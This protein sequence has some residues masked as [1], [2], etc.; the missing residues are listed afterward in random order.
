M[1]WNISLNVVEFYLKFLNCNL[2]VAI[3]RVIMLSAFLPPAVPS[4]AQPYLKAKGSTWIQL[5]WVPLVCDG[6]YD[7]NSYD[8]GYKPS[9]Y[10]YYTTA[11]RTSN[12]NITIENLAA[13][14]NYYFRIQ[15]L[16]SN[17]YSYSYSSSISV[18]THPAGE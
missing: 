15:T 16:S 1:D 11:G 3:D 17:S 4:L 7:V 5:A 9:L 8:V 18:I 6:G 13:N 2:H 10:S 14:T 12:L